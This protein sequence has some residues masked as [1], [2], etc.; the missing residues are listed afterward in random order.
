M[1]TTKV[2]IAQRYSELERQVRSAPGAAARRIRTLQEP[3]RQQLQADCKANGDHVPLLF[4]HC[5][6]CGIPDDDKQ[7]TLARNLT[8]A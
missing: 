6:F 3:E 4:G 5:L 7:Q 8:R 1:P 2:A